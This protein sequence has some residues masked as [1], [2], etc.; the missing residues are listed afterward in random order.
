MTSETRSASRAFTWFLWTLQVIATIAA[1]GILNAVWLFPAR[2]GYCLACRRDRRSRGVD[3]AL[4]ESRR[5]TLDTNDS[6]DMR[7]A[8]CST[9][10]RPPIPPKSTSPRTEQRT[11]ARALLSAARF[12]ARLVDEPVGL[13]FRKGVAID[14]GEFR[15]GSRR[16]RRTVCRTDGAGCCRCRSCGGRQRLVLVQ[17][18]G[19]HKALA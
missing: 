17:R 12:G 8:T 9:A 16:R 19:F 6:K 10:T 7:G 1:E 14:Q 18:V 4:Y 11:A 3:R 2:L 13:Y 15:G 5:R